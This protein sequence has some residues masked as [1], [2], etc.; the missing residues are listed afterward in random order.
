ML[1]ILPL[2]HSGALFIRAAPAIYKG[3]TLV[4]HPKFDLSNVYQDIER[5]KVTKFLAVPTIYKALLNV[6]QEQ[7]GDLSSF[8]IFLES[9]S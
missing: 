5:Y 3:A 9:A 8:I 2:F 4:I 7:R 6:L 1:I